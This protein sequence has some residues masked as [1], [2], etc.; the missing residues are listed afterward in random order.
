[1]SQAYATDTLRA[2]EVARRGQ[3]PLVAGTRDENGL[4]RSVVGGLRSLFR[5]GSGMVITPPLIV[6]SSYLS[7][8]LPLLSECLPGIGY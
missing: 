3:G 7:E 6:G 2:D 1:V 5:E 4:R 8:E